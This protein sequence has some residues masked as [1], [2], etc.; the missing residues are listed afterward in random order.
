MK[1]TDYIDKVKNKTLY[2]LKKNKIFKEITDY[3][4]ING[5]FAVIFEDGSCTQCNYLHNVTLKNKGV[6]EE[7]NKFTVVRLDATSKK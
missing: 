3:S 4:K 2:T 6:I 1:L 7:I 5:P